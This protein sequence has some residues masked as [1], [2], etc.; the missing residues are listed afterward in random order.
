MRPY[1]TRR[2]LSNDQGPVPLGA[3][4]SAK[5]IIWTKKYGLVG[6]DEP[7]CNEPGTVPLGAIVK[8]FFPLFHLNR[9]NS[10]PIGQIWTKKIWACR[11]PRAPSS[12]PYPVPLVAI[13]SKKKID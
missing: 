11:T 7:L 2:N 6:R 9:C 8:I 5:K 4:V 1:W 13:V 12:E 3:I 10:A